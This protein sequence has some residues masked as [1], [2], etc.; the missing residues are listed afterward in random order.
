[1]K[2]QIKFDNMVSVLERFQYRIRIFSEID[3]NEQFYTMDIYSEK[4]PWLSERFKIKYKKST[5]GKYY[6]YIELNLHD[7]DLTV[8]DTKLMM[9]FWNK[10]VE[11]CT[12]LNILA[13][14]YISE[15]EGEAGLIHYLKEAYKIRNKRLSIID[16]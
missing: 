5:Q 1:M 6:F 10:A 3:W 12:H 2:N 7:S 13:V 15:Y 4:H 9:E 8:R 11:L 14:P 16:V